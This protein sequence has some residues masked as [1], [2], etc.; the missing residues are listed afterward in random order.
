MKLQIVL[1][2]DTLVVLH[3]PSGLL[4]IPDRLGVELSLKDILKEKYGTIYT[5][6]RLDKDTS[7]LIVFAKTEDEHRFLSKAFEARDVEKY[8][9]GIVSGVPTASSSTIDEPI[10]EHPVKKGTMI[11][12]R[13]GK[14]AITDFSVLESFGRFSH[15]QFRIHTG[16]THQIRVHMAHIGHP[17]LCDPLYGDGKAVML[18]D[19]K[20]KFNLSKSDWEE[21]PLLA[22]LALHAKK[23]VFSDSKGNVYTTE[24]PLPRDLRALLQQATKNLKK[25]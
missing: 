3:K 7:G 19:F 24:A 20:K 12:N 18:S 9:E 14:S 25:D 10:M 6:H 4:S 23:L 2:T 11:I 22:R 8:Y 17:I 21:R 16:R 1:E 5:I 13:K 15:L